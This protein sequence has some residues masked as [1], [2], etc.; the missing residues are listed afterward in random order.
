MTKTVGDMLHALE[1]AEHVIP[2]TPG[3]QLLHLKRKTIHEVIGE[4][5]VQISKPQEG[6]DELDALGLE[7][8]VKGR[9]LQEGDKLVV[10]VDKETGK[11]WIRFPNEFETTRWK[12]V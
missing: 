11:L 3:M 2:T 6:I 4:G 10:Y 1:E 5:E 7:R 8:P 12:A 9:L